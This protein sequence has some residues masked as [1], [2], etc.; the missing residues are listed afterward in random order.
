MVRP[1]LLFLT[2]P[3]LLA[4]Q[5][6]AARTADSLVRDYMASGNSPSVAI[7]LIRGADTVLFAAY[8][9]AD[10]E[11]DVPATVNS[12]YRIGSVTKQFTAAAVMQ[13]VEQGKLGL[14]DSIGKHLDNLPSEWQSVTVHQLL[15]HTS[16]IPSYTSLG[17]R[18]SRI[19]GVE[20]S[21]DSIIA[22]VRDKAMDF[23]PGTKWAYNNTGYVLLGML[24][25]KIT[26]TTW[27]RDLES[28]FTQP[29]GLDNTLNCLAMPLIPHRVRGY[30]KG[31]D[32][33]INAPYLAMSQPYAAGAMCSTIGDLSSWNRALHTGK[34]VSPQSYQ[35]MTTPSGAAAGDHYGFGLMRDT[36]A[37]HVMI[38]H[39]GGIHGFATGNAWVPDAQLSVS[40][41]T[42]SGSGSPGSLL[43]QLVRVGLG[44]PLDRTPELVP[45]PDEQRQQYVGVYDLVL[46]GTPRPFTIAL[47]D[48][49]LT[50]QL[51]GQ[52]AI[53]ML[54]YGNHTFGAEFDPSLRLIFAVSDGRASKVT[55]LQ[56]GGRFEGERQR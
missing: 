13:L 53:P 6:P 23:P 1:T 19:W 7:A 8:G 46:A 4:A 10:L 43:K 26:G 18:W 24:I 40:V 52:G 48:S 49:G 37:E 22:L 2:L 38:T 32:G 51:Q 17:V 20:M 14:E 16:G 45:L 54:Y 50:A 34:V 15:N 25:E 31:G 5:S 35:L 33:W 42:S 55:L 44:V 12:V 56:G 9:S 30:E 27:G 28:R 39:G 21:P 36:I 41:L 11:H 3:A 29:L 47:A